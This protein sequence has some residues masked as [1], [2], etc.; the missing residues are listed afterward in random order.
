MSEEE[1]EEESMEAMNMQAYEEAQH[2]FELDQ[3]AHEYEEAMLRAQQLEDQARYQQELTSSRMEH[4]NLTPE[5]Y[6]RAEKANA[7]SDIVLK[8][9]KDQLEGQNNARN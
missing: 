9:A 7:F 5:D 8:E 3:A 1:P 6:E 2:Q 4:L